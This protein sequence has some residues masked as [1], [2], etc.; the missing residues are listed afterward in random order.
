MIY[1]ERLIQRIK[2]LQKLVIFANLKMLKVS[3]DK[4]KI[5]SKLYIHVYGHYFL[6]LPILALGLKIVI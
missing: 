4:K 5:K 2:L 6:E 3:Q 1:T